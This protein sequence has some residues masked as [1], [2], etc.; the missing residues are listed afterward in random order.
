MADT[1]VEA[2]V[3]TDVTEKAAI[4]LQG[5]GLTVED[6]LRLFL[7]RTADL[8]DLPFPTEDAEMAHDLWVRAKVQEALDDP[9]PAIPDDEVETYFAAKRAALLNVR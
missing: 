9:R 4:V 6:G 3:D 7:A 8:G 1:L 5:L 2:H